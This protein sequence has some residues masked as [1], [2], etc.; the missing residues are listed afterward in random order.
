MGH[1]D[2]PHSDD[3]PDHD[4]LLQSSG[5]DQRHLVLQNRPDPSR[6]E[7]TRCRDLSRFSGHVERGSDLQARQLEAGGGGG[8]RTAQDRRESMQRSW[9]RESTSRSGGPDP[10]GQ[11]L[12]YQQAVDEL[13]TKKSCKAQSG[14]RGVPRDREAAASLS[15]AAGHGRGGHGRK[16]GGGAAGLDPPPGRK[17][18]CRSRAG[19]SRSGS[20]KDGRPSRR[21]RPRRAIR[22]CGWATSSIR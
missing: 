1:H 7:R 19:S 10:G 6:D 13:E 15:K 14:Q 12:A 4:D 2:L 11:E 8:D 17:G 22:A 3:L 9:W 5:H 20:G 18:Q 21:D 16:A